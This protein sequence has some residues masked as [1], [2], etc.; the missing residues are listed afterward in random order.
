MYQ[1]NPEQTL[2]IGGLARFDYIKGTVIH[3]QYMFRT[4]CQY[5]ARN[6]K[7][8]TDCIRNIKGNYYLPLPKSIWTSCRNL[9]VMNFPLRRQNGYCH[10][11]AW[12]DYR[13]AF[14]GRRSLPC[15]KRCRSIHSSFVNLKRREGRKMKKWFA[16]I[17]DPIAHSKSPFMHNTWFQEM[18]IDAA[19]I[20]I[21]VKRENLREAVPL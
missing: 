2:F 10:F 5:I 18:G 13:A 12:M 19:Y 20:P 4:N 21:H 9:S 17:G 11:R 1:L 8:R 7:K 14:E 3:L 16:V 6:W 15:T